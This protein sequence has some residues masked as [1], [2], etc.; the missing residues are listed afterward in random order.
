MPANDTIGRMIRR[1]AI[2]RPTIDAIRY[3]GTS[4]DFVTLAA[5]AEGVA[6]ALADAGIGKDDRIAILAK[7]H[8]AF[9]EIWAGACM[10]G[11]VLVP[12]NWRLSPREIAFIITD[13]AAKILFVDAEQHARLNE[14]LPRTIAIDGEDYRAWRDRP[15]IASPTEIDPEHIAIQ[16]YTSG[17]TGFPKG[18]LISHR[19]LLGGKDIWRH[20]DWWTWVPEDVGLVAM[21]LFHIGGIGWLLMGLET[22]ATN[23]LMREFDADEILALLDRGG[24][25]KMFIVPT[26]LQS[27]LHAPAA[28]TT[29][30]SSLR[31]ILY[32]ASPMPMPLLREAIA[33]IGCNFAQQYGMTE[34]AGTVIALGPDDHRGE[35][36]PKLNAAG[37]AM[38]TVELRIT[39]TEG[40]VLPPDTLGQVEIRSC[41]NFS[42]YWN[43]PDAT[44]EAMGEDGWLRTGD[45]GLL[46]ADGYLFVLDRIKDMIISGGENIY[47]LE[48]ESMLLEHPAIE[49][50]GVIGLPD[51]RWGE[52]VAA[53]I[54]TRDGAALD[55]AD[56]RM[57]CRERIAA[58]KVP[59]TFIFI[60]ALPRNASGKL[61]RRALREAHAPQPA[62]TA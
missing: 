55:Q 50:V 41:A 42:G 40:N 9:L 43:R 23:H 37:R 48:V 1:H 53:V 35:Q 29:D 47:P 5:R 16:L 59:K 25:T 52:S 28:A 3:E 4:I 34:T 18:A 54:V 21:P 39:D 13:S 38:P 31:T 6:A 26:A 33:R 20:L 44:A 17:T 10:V 58:F 32:G 7:N 60:D 8:P 24:F 30:F 61:L 22:G 56:L 45:A 46:D 49:E 14:P 62:A 51:E 19:A 2:E 36:P 12:I 57:W 15:P 27:L 11:A